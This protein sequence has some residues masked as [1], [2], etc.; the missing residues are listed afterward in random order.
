MVVVVVVAVVVSLESETFN[1]VHQTKLFLSNALH[2]LSR[3][4]KH[5]SFNLLFKLLLLQSFG[6]VPA[7]V[8]VL[9]YPFLL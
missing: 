4:L 3:L 5:Q 6:A 1:A 7:L 8:L 9:V 2:L